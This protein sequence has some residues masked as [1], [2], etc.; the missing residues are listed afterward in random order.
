[1]SAMSLKNLLILGTLINSVAACTHQTIK[2]TKPTL[3]ILPQSNGGICLDKEN[4][5]ELGNYILELEKQ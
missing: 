4:A 5:I 3:K 1:M 2:P